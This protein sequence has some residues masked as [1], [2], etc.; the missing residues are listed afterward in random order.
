MLNRLQ[1]KSFN[2]VIF[3]ACLILAGT[4]VGAE[5]LELKVQDAIAL[6]E[7][8]NLNFR[9]VQIDWRAARADLERAEIV[10]DPEM[11]AEAKKAQAKADQHY[12]E[13]K[14]NLYSLVRTSYQR[15]LEKETA[16]A[17]VLKAKERAENQLA[18]DKKKYE[19]GLLS[20]LD[21][22]RAKNSLFDAEHR[23]EMVLIEYETERMKFNELLGLPFEQK[24]VLTERLLLDFLPF[25]QDLATCVELAFVYDQGILTAQENLQQAKEAVRAAQSPF[26][27]RVE[28]EKALAEEEKVEIGLQ[29]AEQALYLKIRGAY[30][31]LLDQAHELE[32]LELQ[33]ELERKTLQA[34]ESKYAAGVLS[35]AQI[36][37]QQ[38]KLAQLE[39]SYSTA[40][41][42]YSLAR[43][44]LLRTMGQAETARGENDDH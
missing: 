32:V 19:A 23:Y 35:N 5:V 10:G 28:L 12:L 44:E 17:N 16:V 31:A 34:E 41:L 7:E 38:E 2:I 43:Q 14:E 25:T 8:H 15:L 26:T 36:V 11:L 40:L 20:S 27:P 42:N 24:V 39:Q 1:N 6:A 37:A 21:I 13:Q 30:Y 3:T 9:L 18:V 33:I 29:Q 22:Q 4:A